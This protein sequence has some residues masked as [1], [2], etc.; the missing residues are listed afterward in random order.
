MAVRVVCPFQVEGPITET[1][2]KHRAI[3]R[4]KELP[5]H[6]SKSKRFIGKEDFSW[7]RFSHLPK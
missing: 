3:L 4:D 1:A 7:Q 5:P 6:E 2:I